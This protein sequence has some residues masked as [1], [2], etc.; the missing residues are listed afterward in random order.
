LGNPAAPGH[1]YVATLPTPDAPSLWPA[2]SLAALA[3]TRTHAAAASRRAF[4]AATHAAL[5]GSAPGIPRE[6]FSW[7]LSVILSRALS[8]EGGPYTLVPVLD[9]LNHA[10]EPS[11]ACVCVMACPYAPSARLLLRARGDA[12]CLLCLLLA[13]SPAYRHTYDAGAREF[14]VTALRPHAAGEQLFIAYGTHMCN[15]RLLRLYGAGSA[16]PN[17]QLL[18]RSR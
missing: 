14:V 2:D 10:A 5:F 13:S 1:A 7:A 17:A 16:T 18:A 3:G 8:G 12:A 4:V 9:A 15:D 11:C 6:R